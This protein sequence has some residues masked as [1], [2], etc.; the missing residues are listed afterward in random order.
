MNNCEVAKAGAKLKESSEAVTICQ[1][2]IA[3]G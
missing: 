1:T 2:L 3:E